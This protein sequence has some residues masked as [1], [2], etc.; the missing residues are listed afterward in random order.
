MEI[1][2]N[3]SDTKYDQKCWCCAWGL[4]KPEHNESA[5]EE[6]EIPPSNRRQNAKE[7]VITGGVEPQVRIVHL[8]PTEDHVFPYEYTLPLPGMGVHCVAVSPDSSCIAAI[9]V[10]GN[11]MLI[12]VNT[13]VRLPSV[14]HCLVS[15]F[16]STAFGAESNE[17][18]FAGSGNGR[19]FKYDTSNGKL[20]HSY[21]TERCE[22]ILGLAISGDER[23]LGATDYAGRFS[24]IDGVTGQMLRRRNFKHPLRKLVFEPSMKRALVA[25][26]DKTVKL[27][28]LPSGMM[29]HYLKGHD[30]SVMSVAASPDGRLIVSGA[31]DGTIKLWDTR[32]SK[33]TLSF[34][35]GNNTNLWDV[36]FNRHSNKIGFVGDGKGLNVYYCLGGMG[37]MLV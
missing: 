4:L 9:A 35:S 3:S 33:N 14:S 5:A 18:V 16:W 23:L 15:N 22:N 12:D 11:L 21:D 31:C 8:S 27:I 28:D 6:G 19:I 30:S 1:S 10:D 25:C 17:A 37:L 13:G 36:A 34:L 29:F 7:F 2:E 32:N 20:L 24:L 26:D